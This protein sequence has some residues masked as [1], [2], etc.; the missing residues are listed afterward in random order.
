MALGGIHQA[1]AE[2]ISYLSLC[3]A[4]L[5]SARLCAAHGRIIISHKTLYDDKTPE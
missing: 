4:L 2:K 3:S 5:G 1:A